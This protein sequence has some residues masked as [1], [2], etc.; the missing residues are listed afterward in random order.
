M[1]LSESR[2]RRKKAFLYGTVQYS[3]K[4]I[5]VDIDV[6]NCT[7]RAAKPI[8]QT[9]VMPNDA[10][11]YIFWNNVNLDRVNKRQYGSLKG[12]GLRKAQKIV[13]KYGTINISGHYGSIEIDEKDFIPWEETKND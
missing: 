4:K 3:K 7:I 5:V 1:K 13:D 11:K 2:R 12:N 8:D 6:W 10:G 9:L